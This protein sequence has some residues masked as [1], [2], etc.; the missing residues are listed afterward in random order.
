M[1]VE[2]PTLFEA[3]KARLTDETHWEEIKVKIEVQVEIKARV[4]IEV[5]RLAATVNIVLNRGLGF[6]S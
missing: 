6:G 4:E 3:S 2:L 1:A 5:I